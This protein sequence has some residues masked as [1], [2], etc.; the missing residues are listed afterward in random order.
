[1]TLSAKE[2]IRG[3]SA[4]FLVILLSL[5]H[6][7]AG[8][9]T[10]SKATY[11]QEELDQMMAPIALYP[12]SLLSQVLMASTYPLEVV[13]ASRWAEQNKNLKGDALAEAL[14]KE[15][16]DPSVK[17]LVQFN[18]VLAMMADKLDWT[19]K[20]GDAFLGQQEDVMKTVQTLRQKAKE[21]GNLKTT[22][23]QVVKEEQ[24]TIIIVPSD[25]KVVYVPA[26]DPF[27]VYGAWWWPHY[28]PY[29]YYPPYYPRPTLYGFGVGITI[30]VAW[31]YAWGGC[32]W[33]HSHIN[34]NINKNIHLNARIDRDKYRTG[35]GKWQH[36]PEHRKGVAYRDQATAQRFDRAPNREAERTRE[37]FRGRAEEGRLDLSRDGLRQEDRFTRGQDRAGEFSRDNAGQRPSRDRDYDR[38]SAFSGV[39][40]GGG[41]ARDFSSRGSMSR[42]SGF[43]GGRGGGG[44]SGGGGRGGRR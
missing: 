6:A 22:K 23:E 40:R 14:E 20:L 39:D 11:K 9:E 35:S 21:A 16:W 37:A 44:L 7:F 29:Y 18:D 36:N 26:Y 42:G 25:P 19:Q 30:G 27:Y 5:P 4:W 43:S 41:A 15:T 13:Q 1:M 3:A 28:P 32:N 24:Q 31:G 17:S 33:H 8:E 38:G 12:D 34:I 10:K 2:L